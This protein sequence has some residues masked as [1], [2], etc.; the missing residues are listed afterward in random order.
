MVASPLTTDMT[1]WHVLAIDDKRDNLKLLVTMLLSWGATVTATENP[2]RGL[3]LVQECK[4]NL[5]LLDLAM[6]G[7][8]GWE[9]QRRLR[10]EPSLSEVPIIALTALA[11]QD[12]INKAASAGFDGYITKPYR[13][14]TLHE[15]LVNYIRTFVPH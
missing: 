6:P 4:P 8:S 1:T 3:E 12:D 14:D 11:M 7:M 5:I 10:S 15:Q 2:E 9:L 13:V